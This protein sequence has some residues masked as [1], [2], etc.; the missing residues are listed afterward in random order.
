MGFDQKAYNKEYLKRYHQLHKNDPE[1]RKRKREHSRK[2][3]LVH[4]AEVVEYRKLFRKENRDRL[5]KTTRAWRESNPDK[6]SVYKKKY[7]SIPRVKLANL[8][9]NSKRQRNLST[10][11]VAVVQQVYEEN[12]K[13][14]GTLTCEL[15]FKPI[16][17][18]QDS[19]EHFHP[20][21]R[22]DTYIGFDINERSNLGVAHGRGSVELCNQRKNNKTMKE[23]VVDE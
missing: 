12:I 23:W 3:K 18:G 14:Y 4:K 19:L 16:Q 8:V 21:S 17:F 7:N 2:W 11:S 13:K 22:K 5:L 20:V 1:Y 6:V 10:L 15:C 9:R